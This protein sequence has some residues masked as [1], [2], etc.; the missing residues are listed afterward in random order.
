[1]VKKLIALLFVASLIGA[2]IFT[3]STQQEYVNFYSWYGVVPVEIIKQFEQET[4]IKVRYDMYD[5]N[6]TLEAKLLATN[7]GYDVVVPSLSPYLGRGIQ[8]GLYQK[9]DW[10]KLPNAKHIDQRVYTYSQVIDHDS[11]YG[12]PYFW[13]S[14]GIAYVKEKVRQILPNADLSSI[15]FLFKPANIKKLSRCGVSMLDEHTDVLPMAAIY[16]GLDPNTEDPAVIKRVERFMTSIRPYILRFSGSRFVMDLAAGQTCV[17]MAWSGEAQAARELASDEDN[18]YTIEYV[19]PR[20]GSMLWIDTLAIPDGA[21]NVENAYKLI[22]FLLRPDIAAKMTNM[23]YIGTTNVASL[24]MLPDGVRNDQSIF[25][26]QEALSKMQVNKMHKPQI[27]RL[28][29]R[30]W[31]KIRFAKNDKVNKQVGR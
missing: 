29:N 17:A 18:G 16:L 23:T 13:G 4:G 5:S 24:D 11:A 14:I 30:I 8:T 19:V 26:P 10:S 25:P 27:E 21:P 28:L 3:P 7:A 22:N 6:D 1:M 2:Y 15:D 9:L 12:V 20:E 31:T